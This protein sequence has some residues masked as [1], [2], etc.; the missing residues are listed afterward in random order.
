MGA[1]LFLGLAVAGLYYLTRGGAPEGGGEGPAPGHQ[2][3]GAAVGAFR[4]PWSET[5]PEGQSPIEVAINLY[6]GAG[7][8]PHGLIELALAW[9]TVA[10]IDRSEYAIATQSASAESASQHANGI[11][12]RGLASS[13]A[14]YR[15]ATIALAAGLTL[16]QAFFTEGDSPGVEE[17][18]DWMARLASTDRTTLPGS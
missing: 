2:L 3:A 7:V 5:F 13:D 8:E 11:I 4:Y 6:R 9:N 16:M 12:Q 17:T 15:Q 18:A 1:L 14:A 10:D